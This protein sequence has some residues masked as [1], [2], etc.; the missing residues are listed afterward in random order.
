MTLGTI[1]VA[2]EKGGIAIAK[3]AIVDAGVVGLGTALLLCGD[4][5]EVTVLDR[6]AEACRML[7]GSGWERARWRDEPIPAPSRAELLSIVAGD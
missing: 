6:D 3:I 2:S 4:G 7:P 1:T 5:H